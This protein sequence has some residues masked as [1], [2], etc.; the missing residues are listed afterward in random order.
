MVELFTFVREPFVDD[1]DVVWAI[2]AH[3][4]L[5]NAVDNVVTTIEHGVRQVEGTLGGIGPSGGNT[6]LLEVLAR[7]PAEQKPRG[8][9]PA[10]LHRLV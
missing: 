9:D 8:I 4:H 5:G 7:L 10:P 6:D 1:V 3:D 2:H